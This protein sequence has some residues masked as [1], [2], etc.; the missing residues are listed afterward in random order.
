MCYHLAK[1]KGSLKIP[2]GKCYFLITAYN[3]LDIKFPLYKNLINNK[4]L[5]KILHSKKSFDVG[6]NFHHENMILVKNPVDMNKLMKI[7]NQ[8]AIFKIYY[9]N[10]NIK[11]DIIWNSENVIQ[12]KNFKWD[13]K[14]HSLK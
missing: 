9:L 8:K 6:D 1:I 3:P 7:F 12:K 14:H 5:K 2:R 13:S 4:K 11:L 10:N